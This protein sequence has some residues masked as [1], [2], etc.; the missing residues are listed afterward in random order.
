MALWR[1]KCSWH[2]IQPLPL[3]PAQ[4]KAS[5][6]PKS[7]LCTGV[8][9]QD[10]EIP[11]DYV[12]VLVYTRRKAKAYIHIMIM[13]SLGCKQPNIHKT[14]CKM[15]IDNRHLERQGNTTQPEGKAIKHNFSQ[16]SYFSNK[17]MSCLGWDSNPRPSVF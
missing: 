14:R 10:A 5:C 13:N 11:T 16:R 7:F 1:E 17:K 2:V 9:P 12:Y 8:I 6:W 15:N 3:T 4:L